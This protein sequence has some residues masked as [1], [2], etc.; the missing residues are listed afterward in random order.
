VSTTGTVAYLTTSFTDRLSDG[1]VP[2]VQRVYFWFSK[3]AP[4]GLVCGNHMR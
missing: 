2:D 1:T 4:G 3:P